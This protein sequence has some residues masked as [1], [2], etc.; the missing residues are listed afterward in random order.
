MDYI[1]LPALS[2]AGAG[3]LG[4]AAATIAGL[5]LVWR[6]NLALKT[7]NFVVIGCALLAVA[8]ALLSSSTSAMSIYGMLEGVNPAVQWSL[9]GVF[10]MLAILSLA[11][12]RFGARIC[13][14][15]FWLVSGATSTVSIFAAFMTAQIAHTNLMDASDEDRGGA[16]VATLAVSNVEA[17]QASAAEARKAA[18]ARETELAEARKRLNDLRSAPD[19]AVAA[20]ERLRKLDEMIAAPD[21]RFAPTFNQA[22]ANEIAAF[23]AS[24]GL[25][26]DGLVGAATRNELGAEKLRV[27]AGFQGRATEIKSAELAIADARAAA[28]DAAAK[29]TKADADAKEALAAARNDVE[30]AQKTPWTSAIWTSSSAIAGMF[31]LGDAMLPVLAV[32]SAVIGFG[33][34]PAAARVL[35]AALASP[36]ATAIAPWAG[37]GREIQLFAAGIGKG[38]LYADALRQKWAQETA[39]ALKDDNVLPFEPKPETPAPRPSPESDPKQPDAAEKTR[40]REA[41]DR[42]KHAEQGVNRGKRARR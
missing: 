35:G 28:I 12:W 26:A 2:E 19:P 16:R 34:E 31:G 32:L 17:A 39:E 21:S 25:V 13:G 10:G 22:L 1:K 3:L 11:C 8:C 23:Q 30:H 40:R 24:K 15:A 20:A 42:L 14:H 18:A 37:V 41:L 33:M 7:V 38:R 36:S 5:I 6:L 27:E 29:L 9:T 4:A